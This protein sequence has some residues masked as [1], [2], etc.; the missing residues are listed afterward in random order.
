MGTGAQNS[1]PRTVKE[2]V[3]SEMKIFCFG[4]A[5]SNKLRGGVTKKNAKR[6]D[7]VR[8]G[9]GWEKKNKKRPNFNLGILNEYLTQH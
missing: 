4:L 7:N 9:G 3:H 2:E 5:T 8:Y 6:W 1:F